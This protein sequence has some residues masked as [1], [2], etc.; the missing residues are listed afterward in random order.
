M[1]W[2]KLPYCLLLLLWGCDLQKEADLFIPEYPPELVVT[3][4]ISLE[5]GA[6]V[7]ISQ[8]KP[9]LSGSSGTF[10]QAEVFLEE[11]EQRKI[12]LER[13]VDELYRTPMS[14]QPNTYSDY[15][16]IIEAEG[17]AKIH[18]EKVKIP[19]PVHIQS[20]NMT[21]IDSISYSRELVLHV[22][23]PKVNGFY[24]IRYEQNRL[25]NPPALNYLGELQTDRLSDAPYNEISKRFRLTPS[26][27]VLTI[28]LFHL[29]ED[30]YRFS[31][32]MSL[33]EFSIEDEFE[34]PVFVHSNIIKGFGIFGAYSKTS[35]QIQF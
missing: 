20:T 18:S 11:N 32:S 22:N 4:Y 1:N 15:T 6:I 19:E 23:F 8:T 26:D 13:G 14:F 29:S 12:I 24:G 2:R 25:F 5:E 33:Q 3:G 9:P 16:L 21:W 17:F 35:K 7:H 27:S 10:I 31:E 34:D 28:S 30:L